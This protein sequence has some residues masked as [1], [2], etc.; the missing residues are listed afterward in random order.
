MLH[1]RFRVK[2]LTHWPYE[3]VLDV[4]VVAHDE[5]IELS[6]DDKVTSFRIYLEHP[7][8]Y[9]EW[10]LLVED[11]FYGSYEHADTGA[12]QLCDTA[13]DVWLYVDYQLWHSQVRQDELPLKGLHKML[14]E[15]GLSNLGIPE[16]LRP[17]TFHI[18][19]KDDSGPELPLPTK[20]L[21]CRFDKQSMNQFYVSD[22]SVNRCPI[23]NF[24]TV[25]DELQ[26]DFA[27]VYAGVATFNKISTLPT[28]QQLL[29]TL[30]QHAKW[31]D[32]AVKKFSHLSA[33]S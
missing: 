21:D 28:H 32:K 27:F 15:H 24:H 11:D 13:N 3:E 4:R 19:N 6:V 29:A 20:Q 31:F 23:I 16:A 17:S 18:Q 9:V 22:S 2:N 33:S 7:R 30:E 5:P 10:A 25:P 1:K 14:A 12:N 8:R 26:E